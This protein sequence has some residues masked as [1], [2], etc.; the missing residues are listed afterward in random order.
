MER[1]A[2]D[3]LRD[4]ACTIALLKGRMECKRSMNPSHLEVGGVHGA[5][6]KLGDWHSETLPNQEVFSEFP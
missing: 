4:R 2:A 5:L 6:T 1:H 3:G